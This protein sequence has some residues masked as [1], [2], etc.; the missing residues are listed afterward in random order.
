M[1][2][3]RLLYQSPA[4]M[5]KLTENATTVGVYRGNIVVIRKVNKKSVDLNR[6]ILKEL[7]AVSIQNTN[8]LLI[9]LMHNTYQVAGPV[10][11]F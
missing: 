1:V 11:C 6:T 5:I 2:G 9:I 7:N 4:N 3:D 10:E 8:Y